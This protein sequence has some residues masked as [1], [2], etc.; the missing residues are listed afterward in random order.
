MREHRE[1]VDVGKRERERKGGNDFFRA[2]VDFW[3]WSVPLRR[4]EIEIE[5]LS[6]RDECRDE[7]W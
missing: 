6:P 7:W 2:K 3:D 4:T 1:R 5:R